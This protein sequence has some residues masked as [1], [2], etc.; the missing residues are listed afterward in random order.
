MKIGIIGVG[1]VGG[2]AYEVLKEFYEV[3]A[4][5]KYKEEF[6][7]NFDKL[8]GCEIIFL[9]V[10]T[11]MQDN[12]EIDLSIIEEV[13]QNVKNL[14]FPTSPTIVI[15]STAIPGTTDKLS[16][17]FNFN[18]AY[19]PEFLRE[20]H[21]LEDFRNM[22]RVVIGTKDKNV[23]ENIKS[24][25]Q[26]FLPGAKY[27]MTNFKTAE[28]I[29]Y[30]SNTALATQVIMANELFNICKNLEIEYDD[31]KNILL[32]DE[33]IAKN[34]NVPGPDGDFGF[35]GKCFPK[36]VNALIEMSKNNGYNPE[37]FEKMWQQNLKFRKEKD[38]LN[39]KGATSNNN[40]K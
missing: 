39:I 24:I 1:Y 31:V 33:R 19:N 27:V 9:A 15:R 13:L 11:P 16:E 37:F 4:Y 6:K 14:D 8:S 22:N 29:K 36:D 5:D 35:G 21:A 30:A 20:K 12:G 10:P 25:Y 2:T 32:L 3:V 40:F 28:M 26:K 17:K 23:F 7:N 38:W 34:I 18:F